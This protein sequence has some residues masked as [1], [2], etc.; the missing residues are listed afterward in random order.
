LEVE[1]LSYDLPLLAGYLVQKWGSSGDVVL[2][3]G[4]LRRDKIMTQNIIRVKT[5]LFNWLC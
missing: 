1:G 5:S 2:E 3:F 4:L